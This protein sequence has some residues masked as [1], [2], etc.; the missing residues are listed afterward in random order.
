MNLEYNVSNK[1][2]NL[3]L[4]GDYIKYQNKEQKEQLFLD[5]LKEGIKSI[6]ID[7]SN[8]GK[9]DSS[10]VV[11]LFELQKIA[12]KKSI[13]FNLNHMP[14]GLKKLLSL[15][16]AVKLKSSGSSFGNSSV[17]EAVGKWA[18]SV[19][20]GVVDAV[21]F[22]GEVSKSFARFFV[23]KA[24]MRRIDFMFALGD[25]G[26]KAVLIV[27]LISF[28]I[29]LILAFVGSMQLKTFGAEIYVASLVAI[30]MTRIMGAV[31]TGVI[32]AGRTG[33]SYA[34]TIGTMQVNEEIDALKTMGIGATDF[35]VLPR[36]FA[37]IITMPI[38]TMWA[39]F[40]GIFG[41][42]VVGVLFLDIPINQYWELSINAISFNN[43]LVGIIHGLVFGIVIS[44]CG[45]YYGI[46][47]GRNAES[48]GLA[49]TKSVVTSIVWMIVMTG[50]ITVICQEL[51]V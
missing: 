24:I 49:T 3:I 6:N 5:A 23:G 21:S 26:H 14:D 7:A 37:L 40:V 36:V 13:S 18:V 12:D 10:L 25:C 28:M 48:V 19:C 50:I 22:I 29:G 33:A 20:E 16:F 34:A 38:L 15:A 27:S 4:S 35:L 2:I 46:S 11:V 42:G 51:G 9:W 30:S 39:D 45:C 1:E 44:L 31:M 43:F 8:L 41:G 17:L 47:C 32:M